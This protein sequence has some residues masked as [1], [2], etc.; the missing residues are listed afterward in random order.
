MKPSPR[1]SVIMSAYN[2]DD[3]LKEAVDSI[4]DQT[5]SDFEFIIINDGSSDGT[6]DILKN[7]K[8]SRLRI[9]E[10]QNM[11]LTKSLNKGIT[12]SNGEYIARQDADDVSLSE[13]FEK[14]VR[15]LDERSD[16]ALLG[17][18][19][20]RINHNGKEL[21]IVRYPEDDGTIRNRLL[22]FNPFWH[23]S[24]MMRKKCLDETGIYREISDS[25]DDYDLWLRISE[26]YKLANLSEPL[27]KYRLEINSI[28]VTNIEEQLMKR[29]FVRALALER[30]EK[31]TDEEIFR[32]YKKNGNILKET[33]Q[34]NYALEIEKILRGWIHKSMS[35][36]D[37]QTANMLSKKL[38]KNNPLKLKS[39]KMY[40]S[41]LRKIVM[42]GGLK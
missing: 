35:V 3:Y 5:F 9:F 33:G 27:V 19:A 7:Y 21:D 18:A 31:G 22:E 16:I 2:R 32:N 12:F 40:L 8:D 37:Y 42:A 17:T 15:F 10:Q 24:V 36:G 23:T 28:T 39:Y 29:D 4:L 41:S 11:G 13:R 6:H 20:I 34:N 38:L 26:K 30:K 14:Q 1:I 25:V